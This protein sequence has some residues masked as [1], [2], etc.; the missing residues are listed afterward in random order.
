MD[1]K[2]KE[3]LLVRNERIIQAVIEK[4]RRVCLGSVALIGIY[5]SF[6]SD[7]KIGRAHV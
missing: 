1:K 7:D 4:S 3:A 5:G 6:A 2:I